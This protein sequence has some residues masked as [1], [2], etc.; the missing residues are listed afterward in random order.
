[1]DHTSSNA[2]QQVNMLAE[3]LMHVGAQLQSQTKQIT[4]LAMK[5]YMHM[6]ASQS[7][8]PFIC[9]CGLFT[10]VLHSGF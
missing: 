4:R 3:Q 10:Y 9:H 5:L 7:V 6:P 8:L 1:M 2:V